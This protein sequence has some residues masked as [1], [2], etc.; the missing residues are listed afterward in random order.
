MQF[1]PEA[2]PKTYSRHFLDEKLIEELKSQINDLSE[3][4]INFINEKTNM[5]EVLNN[6]VF[7]LKSFNN[8]HMS[9]LQLKID[10]KGDVYPRMLKQQII[11]QTVMEICFLQIFF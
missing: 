5:Y 4:E 1:R 7:D 2:D 6:S 9:L 10:A 3:F 8:C 11:L